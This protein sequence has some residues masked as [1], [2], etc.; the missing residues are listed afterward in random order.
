MYNT[1]GPDPAPLETLYPHWKDWLRVYDRFNSTGV[2]DS[3][4]TDRIGI[5]RG[6]EP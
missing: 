3:E 1:L 2:F 5:S 6:G 4:F